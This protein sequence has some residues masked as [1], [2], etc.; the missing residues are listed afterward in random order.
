MKVRTISAAIAAAG[1]LASVPGA[2]LAENS[3][4]EAWIGQTGETNTISIL[5]QGSANRAGADNSAHRINQEGR[6]NTLSIDQF[7]H[8]NASGADTLGED[9]PE[10]LSQEGDHNQLSVQQHNLVLDA[11]N[12]LG[13]VFQSSLSGGSALAN[14]LTVVQDETGG[15]GTAGHRIGSVTQIGTANGQGENSATL[16]QTGGNNYLG[17]TI[18]RLVQLG[19]ANAASI[20]QSASRNNVAFAR[21]Q[22]DHNR[23]GIEQ[24]DGSQNTVGLFDQAGT[25]NEAE[26]V[27][28]GDRNHVAWV[29]QSNQGVAISG[30]RM[31]LTIAGDDNG[32]DNLGGQ[33]AFTSQTL[34]GS[35]AYQGAF[36]QIGDSN[37][38]SYTVN[39]GN[40]NLAGIMQY[41]DGNGAIVTISH[42]VGTTSEDAARN[43]IGVVQQGDGND[44]SLKIVGSDNVSSTGMDGDRNALDLSQTGN[45]NLFDI[46]IHGSDNN[47][48]ASVSVGNFRGKLATAASSAGLLPGAGS[49]NGDDNSVTVSLSGDSN[50]FAFRQDGIGN[51]AVMLVNGSANQ[52]V[53]DQSNNANRAA[54]GQSG[55]GNSVS[56]VQF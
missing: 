38:I 41:G 1:L 16:T 56:I 54:I 17:N 35:Q 49:Q 21:Q 50:L 44:L 55:S 33:G 43:E 28:S 5:Q 15:D 3:T 10:G 29:L 30:N 8:S 4:N 39:G 7:G 6:F 23:V 37:D 40:E 45:R 47:N 25:R 27:E 34:I 12:F 53:V 19:Y 9:L 51:A 2:A 11:F 42:A 48:S 26:I 36:V 46:A 20:T 18:E 52:A 24:R 22:G 32:G 31:K 13:A 14:L